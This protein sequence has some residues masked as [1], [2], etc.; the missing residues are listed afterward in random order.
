MLNKNAA[1]L[2]K[3]KS[4]TKKIYAFTNILKS[5]YALISTSTPLGNSNFI[6]ASTVFEVDE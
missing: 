1:K 2:K 5:C 6:N 3:R 4:S